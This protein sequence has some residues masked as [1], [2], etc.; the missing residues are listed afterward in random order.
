MNKT[1][2]DLFLQDIQDI[3]HKKGL[4]DFDAFVFWYL[5]TTEDISE[6]EILE[7]ITNK[8]NDLGIDAIRIDK[9]FHTIKVIQSKYSQS[10][11]ESSFNK[12]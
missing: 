6:D 5:K 7:C 11:G 8:S 12:D 9:N 4:K 1:L 2:K 3:S 10:I